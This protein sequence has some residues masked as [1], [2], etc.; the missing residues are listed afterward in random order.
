MKGNESVTVFVFHA[1]TRY[2]HPSL[3]YFRNDGNDV[4]VTN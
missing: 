4:V 3:Y 2:T 1:C